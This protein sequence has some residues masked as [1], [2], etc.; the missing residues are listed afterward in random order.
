MVI[1]YHIYKRIIH[2]SPWNRFQNISM[3]HDRILARLEPR[4]KSLG[5]NFLGPVPVSGP[6]EIIR[7]TVSGIR[8]DNCSFSDRLPP[9]DD[10]PP[11]CSGIGKVRSCLWDTNI[12]VL[13]RF[14]V[15]TKAIGKLRKGKRVCETWKNGGS[16][17]R[18]RVFVNSI[19]EGSR[20][21]WLMIFFSKCWE[22]WKCD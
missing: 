22:F 9:T 3:N 16:N 12:Y 5:Q 17:F 20:S 4:V 8:R 15:T 6:I 18:K 7:T 11:L 10:F 21:G 13:R 2:R 19:L 14:H 1:H